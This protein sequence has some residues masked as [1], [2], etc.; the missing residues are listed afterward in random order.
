MNMFSSTHLKSQTVVLVASLASFSIT[1]TSQEIPKDVVPPSF[2]SYGFDSNGRELK[3]YYDDS[4]FESILIKYND[5]A[6][7][8]NKKEHKYDFWYYKA[9]IAYNNEFESKFQANLNILREDT[10]QSTISILKWDEIRNLL[11]ECDESL[12]KYDSYVLLRD[13]R[14]RSNKIT[15]FYTNMTSIKSAIIGNRNNAYLD[16]L[17]SDF[18][19]PFHECYP[20]ST[21]TSQYYLE[22]VNIIINYIKKYNNEKMVKLIEL[23]NRVFDF[24]QKSKI[25]IHFLNQKEKEGN[26]TELI[27]L[28]NCLFNSQI[29][30]NTVY[31]FINKTVTFV[32]VS[33]NTDNSITTFPLDI[34]GLKI[35]NASIE[36]VEE[37]M[38]NNNGNNRVIIFHPKEIASE[39]NVIGKKDLS[40]K[41]LAGYRSET[42]QDHFNAQIR[43][44]QA[45]NRYYALKRQADNYRPVGPYDFNGVS[46]NI[47]AGYAAQEMNEAQRVLESTPMQI[48]VPQ[49]QKY[50]YG[51]SQVELIKKI[52]C[53]VYYGLNGVYFKFNDLNTIKKQFNIAYNLDERDPEINNLKSRYS[54]EAQ[55]ED[56]AKKA[57]TIG[58]ED[59]FSIMKSK[60]ITMPIPVNWTAELKQVFHPKEVISQPQPASS[61]ADND[62]RMKSIV[63][64]LNPKGSIGSGFYVARNLVI[65]NYHV[66]EG[67]LF[68][69]VK[70]I[71]G[72][73]CVAKVIK[74]D[75][76][77]DLALLNISKPGLPVAFYNDLPDIG[78]SVDAI[79]HPKGLFF[80]LTRGIISAT[81]Y[82]TNPLVPGS[83]KMLVIQTDAA[84]N[85]GNS[86]G[87]L[88]V[89]D[90]V[91]GINSQKLSDKGIEGLGFALHSS[92]I[93]KFINKA[94]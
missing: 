42:N 79:G 26:K 36:N 58:P 49:Y 71:D 90:K 10:S 46:L 40:S 73:L 12:Q 4:Q 61:S 56:D 11:K 83:N 54:Q 85:P 66:I 94:N 38:R 57:V 64:I 29:D 37:K 16:Y 19:E 28:V 21:E 32:N 91:I 87:P 9:A 3:K 5:S 25:L 8:L 48:D 15:S 84:I 43:F 39:K 34:S 81:R 88:F 23:H 63:V 75:I 77:L 51:I 22:Y 18:A 6:E 80:S 14:F 62:F 74:T 52:N 1:G 78:A 17:S 89:G 55:V 65:T 47:Q 68:P 59:I 24:D 30:K 31:N 50:Q 2:L 67:T 60:Y 72:D 41:F 33:E 13:E 44:E 93:I 7:A 92:E 82:W 86:G 76:G 20:L 27:E 70:N 45:Q 69:E 53:D 35:N